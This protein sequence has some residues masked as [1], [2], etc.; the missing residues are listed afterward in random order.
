MKILVLMPLSESHSHIAMAIHKAL[1][2]EVREK[3]F[4]MPAYIDYILTTKAVEN[5]ILAVSNAL[6]AAQLCWKQ[7]EEKGEDL[8][9]FGNI[10]TSFKFDVIFNCQDDKLDMPYKDG[11]AE[12]MVELVKGT[13][14]EYIAHELY[15]DKDSKMALHNPVAI[16]DF[17]TAYLE[18]DPHLEKIAAE[19]ADRLKA[20]EGD[21]DDGNNQA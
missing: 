16:A 19:Y 14:V 20:L 2:H 12:K 1:P 4:I 10:D 11:R 17:L 7:A 5:S 6:Y 8:I 13:D 3:S 21:I 15:T 9:I 18:T